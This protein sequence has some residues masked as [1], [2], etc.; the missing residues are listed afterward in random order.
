MVAAAA[1]AAGCEVRYRRIETGL[2]QESEDVRRS[3]DPSKVAGA[4]KLDKDADGG[5]AIN[6]DSRQVGNGEGSWDR[7]TLDVYVYVCVCVCVSLGVNVCVCRWCEMFG[8][9]VGTVSAG[10]RNDRGK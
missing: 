3:L 9:E 4:D 2:S 5:E 8:R 10:V 6:R 1:A 7:S